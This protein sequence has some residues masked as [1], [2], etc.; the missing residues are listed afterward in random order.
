LLQKYNVLTNLILEQELNR[1]ENN[2]FK[3]NK[4]T[5]YE[6]MLYLKNYALKDS[7]EIRNRKTIQSENRSKLVAEVI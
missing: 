5:Q 6:F 2:K 7:I 4:R 1:R 3:Q